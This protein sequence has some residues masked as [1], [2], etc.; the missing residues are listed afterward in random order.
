[1]STA[2][3][4]R[5]HAVVVQPE[6]GPSFWQPVPANGHADP[7]L[8]RTNTRYDGLSMGYQTIA[9]GGR[10][11][12]HSHGEGVELQICFRGQG[13]VV[14][15]GPHFTA[16]AVW[17]DPTH[18]AAFSIETFG[19]FVAGSDRAYYFDFHFSAV[20]QRRIVF[21]RYRWQPWNYVVEPLV[22]LRPA[23][24]TFYE[25]TFL[26]RLFPAANVRVTLVK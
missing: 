19:F 9:A 7:K 12:E 26:S 3:A 18:R 11:R 16:P 23:W 13:R 15:E 22:N 4:I 14:V 17:I 24:Q 20:A 25:E 21:H 1:M 6:E 5:G 2:H 8:T 10:V